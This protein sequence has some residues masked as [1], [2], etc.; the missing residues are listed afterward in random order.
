LEIHKRALELI[1]GYKFDIE[2]LE[3]RYA[4]FRSNGFLTNE[5]INKRLKFKNEI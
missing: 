4:S 3:D 1:K 2:R 5:I